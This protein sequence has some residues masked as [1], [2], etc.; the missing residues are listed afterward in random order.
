MSSCDE[1]IKESGVLTVKDPYDWNWDVI[2]AV[3]KVSIKF[4]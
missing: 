3:L 1:A 2:R 4:I